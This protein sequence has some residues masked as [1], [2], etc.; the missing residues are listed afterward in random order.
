MHI[1]SCGVFHAQTPL[2]TESTRKRIAN[3]FELELYTEDG[4]RSYINGYEYPHN[5]VHCIFSK[6]GAVRFSVGKI[7]CQYVHFSA[8]EED[9]ASLMAIPTYIPLATLPEM[10]T[11]IRKAFDALLRAAA[12]SPPQ[13]LCAIAEI[14]RIAALLEAQSATSAP[15]PAAAV[16]QFAAIAQTKTYIE[17]HY[18]QRITLEMLG[19][20]TFLS[21]NYIRLKFTEIMGV[22]PQAYLTYIRV[23]H[24]AEHLH[25]GKSA[26]ETAEACGFSNQSHMI[27]AFKKQY[28]K[29]PQEWLRGFSG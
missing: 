8:D 27:R 25:N 21:K 4:G 14:Y 12:A 29:T 16:P 15:S 26:S 28:G 2:N 23:L 11:T 9:T 5:G 10:Q 24:A 1:L 20:L 18:S 3:A 13:H 7:H 19:K 22:S 6:P 17:E